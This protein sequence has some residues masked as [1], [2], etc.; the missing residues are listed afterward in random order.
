[1]KR[2]L[3]L[4]SIIAT[5]ATTSAS[6]AEIKIGYLLPLSGGGAEYG[7]RQLKGANLAIEEFNKRGDAGFTIQLVTSDTKCTPVEASNAAERLV[8]R[9]GIEVMIGGS[10]SPEA[11]A[12][13]R[14][15]QKARIPQV[16]PTAA[17]TSLTEEGNP[18][19]F[20]IIPNTKQLAENLADVLAERIKV[21]QIATVYLNDDFGTDL[22]SNL[23]ARIQSKG[24]KVLAQEGIERTTMDF[25]SIA[26]KLKPL[27]PDVVVAP[28]FNKPAAQ[29]AR[30]MREQGMM[31]TLSDTI[32]FTDDFYQL[33]GPAAYGVV[34]TTFFHPTV[35]TIR[36]RAFVEAFK[37]KYGGELPGNFEAEGYDAVSVVI[38]ALKRSGAAKSFS[39]DAV[40]KALRETHEFPG[41]MGAITF[42]EKGQV[43]AVAS[44]FVLIRNNQGKVEAME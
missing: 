9:D 27:N 35:K 32:M 23:V 7:Q 28:L 10:C 42:D 31:A 17:A 40:T 41:V 8:E 38:D 21:K 1:M 39:K 13:L 5:V 6:A 36:G 2:L 11:A 33:A 43:V 30:A 4:A 19:I 16:V 3:I 24:V 22:N 12:E 29:L 15:T 26:A 37:A 34:Q 18:Y 20:R 14:V 44:K 25:F